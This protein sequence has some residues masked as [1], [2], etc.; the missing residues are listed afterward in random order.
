MNRLSSPITELKPAYEVV[1][2]GSGYGGGIAAS[3]MSRL[4]KKVCLLEK[5][6][7]FLP[8]EFPKTLLE[9]SP[10]MQVNL[11]NKH[12]GSKNGLYE[13]VV[14]DGIN[15]FKGCGL[16][17]TSLVN[18]NVSIVP[19]D[20][21]F[22]DTCWPDQIRN[23]MNSLREGIAAAWDML[24]PNPYPEGENGYPVLAKTECMRK[25]A[26]AMNEP[27]HLAD[28]NVT[29]ENKRNHVGVDQEKCI[30]CGDCVTGCN[31]KAKNT[32]YMNYLPD[33]K[34]HGAEIFTEIGV[35][36]IEKSGN[37]W[38]V[39]FDIYDT[40]RE[41]FDAP[42]MFIKADMIFV[43]AGSIGSTEIM[44]RSAQKGLP[45]SDMLGKKFTGNGDVLGFGYNNDEPIHG[46]GLGKKAEEGKIAEVGPCITSVIDMRNKPV[47]EEGM[48]LEE[49]SIPGPIHSI[50]VPALVPI[51]KFIGKDTDSGF[52][53]FMKEKWRELKSLLGGAYRGALDNTQVYLVMTHDSGDGEIVLEDNRARVQW[54]GV[55]KEAIFGKVNESLKNA[56]K[57][58][59]GTYVKNPT[60]TKR[61]DFDLV[62][63]HPLGGCA[64]ADDASAGVVDHKG[65]VY[66]GNSG[67]KLHP[68]LFVLD[69]AILPRPVGTN[70]LLTISGL[71]E[72]ACREIAT[73]MK[74]KPDYSFPTVPEQTPEKTTVGIQFTE[75]MKG[76]F[77]TDEKQDYQKAYEL[78]KNNQS[79]FE[80][81]LTIRS[82]NVDRFL[83][84]ASHEAGMIG[85]VNAPA[86]SASPIAV[87]QGRF[88]L[89][90][91][92]PK[93]PSRKK[94]EYAM[95]LN[96]VDGK[97]Y[98]FKGFKDIHNDKGFDVWLDTTT[99]FVTLFGGKDDK[100]TVLGKGMLKIEPADFA[101]QATTMKAL[102][103]KTEG[104]KLQALSRFGKYFAGNVW[105][106]YFK[107]ART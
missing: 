39:Y 31:H 81:T 38:L 54:K 65:Q 20:R 52:G 44:L 6:K 80:F 101:T 107:K 71:A 72:R 11:P 58:L 46:I 42:P 63:V 103:A 30:N 27:F 37:Q 57:A 13:F 7:E 9:A 43:C 1:V 67:T 12:I 16:G 73:E 55:G 60:W 92:D 90:T 70:P 62:T 84:E 68:G 40:G 24:K 74:M 88:N 32:T 50:M 96:C 23:N 98:Y 102:Y 35:S 104:E 85:T 3:R 94:M 4:G 19:E 93:D 76:Y 95:L 28:I 33:A 105:D 25:S 59:G 89:F 75:T 86:L 41:K 29:F 79:P 15:V 91:S 56:T 83:S 61:M 5:G 36:H 78:G 49:G 10:E 34:N 97:S 77:S 99:L 2:I 48:T 26:S 22:E 64:M 106:T 18:A 8:G 53:D 45:V 100:A 14:G 51:S 21:V 69:G 87:T 82:E 47:L 66:S 17:G